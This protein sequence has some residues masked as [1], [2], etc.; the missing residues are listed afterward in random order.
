MDCEK[1]I[2]FITI[3]STGNLV[4]KYINTTNDM[5]YVC[6]RDIPLKIFEFKNLVT[7]ARYV[8]LSRK[9]KELESNLKFMEER[10]KRVTEKLE[11]SKSELE[12]L[13]KSNEIEVPVTITA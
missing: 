8:E 2:D 4:I 1:C 11:N 5:E 6:T 3:D 10:A 7:G 13:I 12:E 9:I